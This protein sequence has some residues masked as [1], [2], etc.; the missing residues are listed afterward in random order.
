MAAE[1]DA[2]LRALWEQREHLQIQINLAMHAKQPDALVLLG[3]RTAL[4]MLE[5]DIAAH[6]R[7]L[8]SAA[9][10]GPSRG[11]LKD[12]AAPLSSTKTDAAPAG[13]ELG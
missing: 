11:A 5:L 1:I 9:L 13:E 3:H 7:A 8:A 2:P 6:K 10:A 4:A 12:K